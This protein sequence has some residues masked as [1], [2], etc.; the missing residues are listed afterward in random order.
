MCVFFFKYYFYF[1]FFSLLVSLT[2]T[3]IAILQFVSDNKI[4]NLILLQKMHRSNSEPIRADILLVKGQVHSTKV[5]H[6]R[7]FF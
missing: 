2:I 5:P 7:N 3:D 4:L 6:Q 1:L